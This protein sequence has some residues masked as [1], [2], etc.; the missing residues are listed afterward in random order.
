DGRLRLT[1][2]TCD[3]GDVGLRD[4]ALVVHDVL[5]PLERRLVHVEIAAV[6]PELNE[7]TGQ[8][9]PERKGY[10]R[11][12]T[13]ASDGGQ[14]PRDDAPRKDAGRT[15]IEQAVPGDPMMRRSAVVDDRP[16]D[17]RVVAGIFVG[18]RGSRMGGLAKGLLEA[19]DGGPIVART[20]RMLE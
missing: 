1:A 13:S 4:D 2:R 19:P 7:V 20:E 18:G 16:L 10:P 12:V 5:E 17:Q 11:A 8:G 3:G 6:A 15:G 14:A 9:A